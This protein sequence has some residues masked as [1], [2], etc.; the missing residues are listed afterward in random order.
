MFSLSLSFLCWTLHACALI[1]YVCVYFP[2]LQPLPYGPGSFYTLF[3][4]NAPD[5][6]PQPVTQALHHLNSDFPQVLSEEDSHALPAHTEALHLDIDSYLS[7]KTFPVHPASPLTPRPESEYPKFF[8]QAMN[9]G[10]ETRPHCLWRLGEPAFT[11]FF[12]LNCF[13]QGKYVNSALHAG[14]GQRVW[15]GFSG[16]RIDVSLWLPPTQPTSE[17]E[18]RG[19]RR[20][21]YRH[22]RRWQRT[23]QQQQRRQ[24]GSGRPRGVQ[25]EPTESTTHDPAGAGRDNSSH[26]HKR[27]QSFKIQDAQQSAQHCLR[28]EDDDPLILYWRQKIKKRKNFGRRKRRVDEKPGRF[29]FCNYHEAGVHYSG[30][31]IQ[32]GSKPAADPDNNIQFYLGRSPMYA[33]QREDGFIGSGG[34]GGGVEESQTITWEKN[35]LKKDKRRRT[36]TKLMNQALEWCGESHRIHFEYLIITECDFLHGK[37]TPPRPEHGEEKLFRIVPLEFHSD[38]KKIH[39]DNYVCSLPPRI[40]YTDMITLLCHNRVE[41]QKKAN[42][43]FPPQPSDGWD[44]PF[45]ISEGS[46][47]GFVGFHGGEETQHDRVSNQFGY[48]FQRHKPTMEDIGPAGLSQARFNL[49]DFKN[50]CNTPQTS[51]RLSYDTSS[52][53]IQSSSLFHWQYKTRH[54]RNF[55]LR[56][57]LLYNTR[58]YL[59]PFLKHLLQLRWHIKKKDLAS[60]RSLMNMPQGDDGMLAFGIVAKLIINSFYG[61][62]SLRSDRFAQTRIVSAQT[63]FKEREKMFKKYLCSDFDYPVPGPNAFYFLRNCSMFCPFCKQ[64]SRVSVSPELRERW[65]H[66]ITPPSAI[67]ENLRAHGCPLCQHPVNFICPIILGGGCH[68]TISD[69][70]IH[71]CNENDDND[72]DGSDNNITSPK[73]TCSITQ[74]INTPLQITAL[75]HEIHSK[76]RAR[77]KITTPESEDGDSCDIS[78]DQTDSESACDSENSEDRAF[79]NDESDESSHDSYDTEKSLSNE[80]DSDTEYDDLHEP[81]SFSKSLPT[82]NSKT[83]VLNPFKLSQ[84]PAKESKDDDLDSTKSTIPY[85]RHGS[86]LNNTWSAI[87]MLTDRPKRPRLNN[88]AAV[89]STI[90]GNSKTIFFDKLHALLYT[91]SSNAAMLVYTDT[92]SAY[93]SCHFPQLEDNCLNPERRSLFKQWEHII[94]EKPH[95]LE[96]QHGKFNIESQHDSGIFRAVKCKLLFNNPNPDRDIVTL[97]GIPRG[98]HSSVTKQHFASYDPAQWKHWTQLSPLINRLWRARSN[99][100]HYQEEWNAMTSQEQESLLSLSNVAISFQYIRMR[101]MPSLQVDFITDKRKISSGVNLKRHM[102][103]KPKHK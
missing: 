74:T 72:D 85:R 1:I 84:N 54:L 73:P 58:E 93:F 21:T 78:D 5:E 88:V 26:Q 66:L 71:A 6:S 83:R 20:T 24:R 37:Y 96:S 38:M 81:A 43:I 62:S 102:L 61:F 80:S 49:K 28:I 55:N 12:V 42:Q 52:L 50:M 79:I 30:H 16:D 97:K 57:V 77:E 86:R 89:A 76:K 25:I 67:I 13:P 60:L 47:G 99:I 2:G 15:G 18:S 75:G 34:E 33:C 64:Y 9:S 22:G 14:S 95:T 10:Y 70:A 4:Q 65:L 82:R 29:I 36:Y 98:L 90:L 103:V 19:G 69:E 40:S 11:Q 63:I 87:Y 100:E 8:F 92:D 35:T 32:P 48:C 41:F 53:E 46:M 17:N 51:S 3:R 39:G 91:L 45:G 101:S 68:F 31:G 27:G 94:L 59:T 7:D 56:H 23:W 44:A